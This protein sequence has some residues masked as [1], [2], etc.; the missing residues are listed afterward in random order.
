[1]SRIPYLLAAVALGA[2]V[3]F[4]PGLNAEVARRLGTPVG[5]AFVSIMIAFALSAIYLVVT[6]QA[7]PVS[8]LASLPPYLWLGGVIGFL[9][10]IGALYVAPALGAA[11]LFAAIVLG[12]MIAAVAADHFGIG[13]YPVRSIDVAR[14][15]GIVLVVAGVFLFER[16]G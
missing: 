10:V 8:A 7:F 12:Q 2:I 6:R 4:Q 15:G 11:V 13:G 3:A 1:L 14:I 16:A 5:A 9:F